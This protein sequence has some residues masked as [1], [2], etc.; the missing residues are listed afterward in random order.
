MLL[1]FVCLLCFYLE[2]NA[3]TA[4][5]TSWSSTR[6]TDSSLIRASS[7]ASRS[8]YLHSIT[9]RITITRLT[10]HDTTRH[11]T[12]RHDT[13]RPT[14]RHDQRH[15][16]NCSVS[17]RTRTSWRALR[18][19]SPSGG[20]TAGRAPGRPCS[21][22]CSWVRRTVKA[23]TTTKRSTRTTTN[24]E[25]TPAGER[26]CAA[27][28]SVCHVGVPRQPSKKRV[29]SGNTDPRIISVHGTQRPP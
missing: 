29:K 21:L 4:A 13:T 11:D 22:P 26:Q 19:R 1:F 18:P 15:N 12:T 5:W 14:T 3:R 23:L 24:I 20:T 27:A 9:E 2:S 25:T 8:T 7:W 16:S 10:R 28:T 6:R 17:S